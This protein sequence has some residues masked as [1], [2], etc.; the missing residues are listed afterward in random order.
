MA[1]ELTRQELDDLLG[2]FAL[3][4]V[5]GDEREQVEQYLRRS[6]QARAVV[7]EYRETA[8][9]LAHAGTEAPAGLW[10][11]IQETLEEE[12]PRLESPPKVIALDR[13]RTHGG[14]RITAAVA[15][16]AA[17]L[18]VGALVVK[19]VQQDNRISELAQKAKAGGVLAAAEAASRDPSAAKVRLSS[20]DGAL[21]ARVVYQSDGN[22]FLLQ[23]NLR[24]LESDFTYQLWALVGDR[25]SPRAI[26]AA[27]LGPDPE[28]AA[29]RVRG[30]VVGFMIT[31]ERAPGVVSSANPAVVQGA[32]S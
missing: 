6:A 22:G 23:S 20:T 17:V 30:P 13:H 21:A 26:S 9:L 4:A 28:V 3:D 7:A 12:P 8:A 14:R 10:E 25:Q 11:R 2:A 32:V 5:D 15:A 29:F 1:R 31:E 27:V 24:R 18:V 16:A 19:N